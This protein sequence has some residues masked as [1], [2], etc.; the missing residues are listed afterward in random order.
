MLTI[1][2][3]KARRAQLLQQ[4]LPNSVCLIPA[5][6]A[7]T[8][9]RDT[10]YAFRQDSYFQYLSGFPEPQAWLLLSNQGKGSSVL[11]C[12]DK[13]EHAEIW[14]GRRFG[15]R[16]ARRQFEFDKAFSLEEL[17]EYALELLNGHRHLYFA[18]GHS[19][20]ADEQVFAW[21][22][23]LRDAPKQS[24]SPPTQLIDVRP[25][26]DEMRL[27]KSAAEIALMRRAA[28]ISAGAHV[29]AMQ[30]ARV[31]LNEYH[32]EAEL[33][34]EF[35]IHG[36]RHPAY[37]TI[38]GS[39]DNA[40]ILHYTEN[41]QSLQDGTLVLIDAGCELHGYAAD[42]TRTFPVNGHFSQ[43]QAQLY[44]L[45]LD[46]QAAA[47]AQLRPGATFKQVGDA[48]IAVLTQGLI[49]LGLLSGSLATNLEHQ[50]YRQFYMHGIGHWLGMDVHDV[51]HYK[52]DGHERPLQPGMVLTIEP[53]LYVAS[54][55]DVDEQWQGIG[56]R[57]EDNV[58]ITASGYDNLTADA[59]KQIE[60]IEA[61]MQQARQHNP[62]TKAYAH[63]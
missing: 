13:D 20:E 27:I 19:A 47:L 8:R 49:D 11:F 4:M 60:H 15:P 50:H 18:Q 7:V 44:Q 28:S 55:A 10:E 51:G 39:G 43:S 21:L 56:I 34:H 1:A 26:L 40:C 31:G 6:H 30:A 29:R 25:V 54:D 33:H 36:A 32:L 57:I 46:A 14:H 9:S 38:V 2:E 61:L 24:M 5:A 17:D 23:A 41:S 53:G 52:I 22:Q 58:L 63:L 35:A 3:F 59:P 42:I 48:A 62:V 37:G 45:V 12:Q 16:E